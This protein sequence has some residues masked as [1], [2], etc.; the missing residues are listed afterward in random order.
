MP[1]HS[2]GVDLGSESLFIFDQIA[3]MKGLGWLSGK[4]SSLPVQG[5]REHGFNP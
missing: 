2:Y 4:E 3:M 5:H 1:L